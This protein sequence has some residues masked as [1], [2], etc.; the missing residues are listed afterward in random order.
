[1]TKIL[2]FLST[3]TPDGKLN[4]E[5]VPI[6]SIYPDVPFPANVLTIPSGVIFRIRLL[7]VSATITFPA[8]STA[9]PQ[10]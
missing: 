10:G 5:D 1:M 4:N 7:P 2:S 6:P 9:I 3:A 8:I